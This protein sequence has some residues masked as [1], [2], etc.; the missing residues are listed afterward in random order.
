M[1]GVFLLQQNSMKWLGESF[2]L[3]YLSSS[4]GSLLAHFSTTMYFAQNRFILLTTGI[5]IG[6]T[7][8]DLRVKSG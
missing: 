5:Y 8:I 1:Q 4:K 6:R 7:A 3:L 2:L